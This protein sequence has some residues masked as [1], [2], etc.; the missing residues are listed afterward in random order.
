M[1][2]TAKKISMNLKD[3]DGKAYAFDTLAIDMEVTEPE[4][5]EP[6][7]DPG[8]DPGDDNGDDPFIG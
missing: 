4:V 1:P 5:F 8:N 6:G 2:I 3:E 7:D